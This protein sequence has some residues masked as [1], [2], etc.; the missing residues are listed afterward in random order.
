MPEDLLTKDI[1]IIFICHYR[2]GGS[3]QPLVTVSSY[4]ER[5]KRGGKYKIVE[6]KD[7]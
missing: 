4:P 3:L 5:F 7:A 6:V 1:E 2:R